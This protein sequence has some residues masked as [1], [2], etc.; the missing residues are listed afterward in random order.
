MTM[1]PMQPAN[2]LSRVVTPEIL[3]A[4]AEHDPRAQRSRRD[5]QRINRIIASRHH[6]VRALRG[7]TM[8]PGVQEILELGAGD[9]TL[10]LRLA[11]PLS[12][13]W[14]HAH[15]TLL[16]Q[17]NLVSAATRTALRETGWHVDVLVMNVMQWAAQPVAMLWDLVMV[18]LFLH[19]FHEE[20]L[21]VLLRAIAQRTD[22]FVACEPRRGRIP[23]YASYLIG[24]LGTNN[25]T[26]ADAVTSVRA[27]FRAAELS[28][29]WPTD[30]GVW[31]L[32]EYAAG[33]FS[34]CFVAQRQ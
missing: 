26:R 1:T 11:A 32:N 22:R 21:Q 17:Q 31:H 23:L 12:S 29:L 14:P 28:A 10:M 4:L 8:T 7:C 6:I 34:H 18:N 30:C 27:G 13:V 33:A 2:K 24:A 25:V 15:V 3:D 20:E 9:G 16:D 5:L 19:H